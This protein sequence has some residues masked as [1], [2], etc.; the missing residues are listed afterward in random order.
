MMGRD[1]IRAALNRIFKERFQIVEPGVDEN[2]RDAYEF[3][4]IDAVELLHEIEILLGAKLTQTEKKSAMDIRTINQIID[5]IE[6]LSSTRR[7][8]TPSDFKENL[9]PVEQ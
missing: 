3:D 5:Y 4:S 7:F 9:S 2:L 1:Q 6:A 8:A